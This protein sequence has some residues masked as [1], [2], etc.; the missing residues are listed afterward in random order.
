VVVQPGI[1]SNTCLAIESLVFHSTAFRKIQT[2]SDALYEV[3][4]KIAVIKKLRSKIRDDD[5]LG[6]F[7]QQMVS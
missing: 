6:G 7:V 1:V 5:E 3:K 2:Q 4:C